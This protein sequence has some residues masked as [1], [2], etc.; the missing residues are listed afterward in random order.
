ML[1]TDEATM[2]LCDACGTGW[3]TGCLTPPLAAVPEGAWICPM[4]VTAGVQRAEVQARAAAAPAPVGPT[5]VRKLSGA[6]KQFDGVRVVK[7]FEVEGPRGGRVV[8]EFEGVATYRGHLGRDAYFAVRYEDG[9]EEEMHLADLK[10][11]VR[12]AA[13]VS[14]PLGPAQARRGRA[15]TA[16]VV[17]MGPAGVGGGLSLSPQDWR[18]GM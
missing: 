10:A 16:G 2:L 7:K 3:H 15:A 6:H 5:Y 4:C 9:D 13:L 12:P 8:K 11:I 18:S 14:L 17:H 1:P